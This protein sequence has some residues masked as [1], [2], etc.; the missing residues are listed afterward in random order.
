MRV[1]VV[2][3]KEGQRTRLVLSLMRDMKDL[4]I[5]K[6]VLLYCNEGP[7]IM[8]GT[9]LESFN[10]L[11]NILQPLKSHLPDYCQTLYCYPQYLGSISVGRSNNTSV[12]ARID[13]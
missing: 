8:T 10:L 13:T 1:A 7:R 6:L 11:P 4:G 2:G 12:V 9:H 3:V 5:G